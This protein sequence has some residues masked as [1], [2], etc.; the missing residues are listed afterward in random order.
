MWLIRRLGIWSHGQTREQ[1]NGG[2]GIP[3]WM[4]PNQG[5][6][7]CEIWRFERKRKLGHKFTPTKKLASKSAWASFVDL[8]EAQPGTQHSRNFYPPSHPVLCL[9]GIYLF[10]SYS[11]WNQSD[12]VGMIWWRLE[13]RDLGRQYELDCDR[14]FARTRKT[15]VNIFKSSNRHPITGFS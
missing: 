14:G 15:S 9:Q 12:D 5:F 7:S 11:F 2:Y 1:G 10:L 4:V 6:R 3:S 8:L 13:K